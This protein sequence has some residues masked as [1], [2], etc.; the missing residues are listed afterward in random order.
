MTL[1][2]M[3]VGSIALAIHVSSV[4]GQVP[5]D[6]QADMIL[7]SA[8]KAHNDANYPFAIQ[9]Y[10][11]FL[12]KFGN[13]PQ[14]N[15]ARYQLALAYLESP[16]R[17]YDKAIEVLNPIAGNTS[18]PEHAYA[19]YYLGLSF[20]GQGLKEL[21]GMKAKPNEAVQFKQR[22]DQKFNEATQ[23]FAAATT[24][25]RAKLPKD[26]GDKLPPEFDWAA[27]ARC[28]QAEMELR[29]GKYKEAKATAEPFTKD[30]QLAK[31][32]YH[33]LGLYLHG[34]ASFQLH[35]YLVAGR[36]LTQLSPFDDPHFGL[37]ARYLLG[38]VYQ[39]T[40]QKAEAAQAFEA[41]LA[42]YE[43]QKK[44]AA[45]KLKRADLLAKDPNERMRL[46][47]IVRNP[48][49][50]HV[51]ASVF[52]SACLGYEA[53]KFG[54]ALGKFQEFAK[55]YPRSSL[56]P[57]A[58]L[59]VGF[60]QVRMKM[61]PE[62]IATLQPMLDKQPRLVDQIQFWL[63]KAQAGAAAAMTD[64]TKAAARDGGFKTAIATLRSAADK[65]NAMANSDPDAKT[66]RAEMLIELAD[67]QQ[68]AK[69]YKDAAST[70]E[71]ILNDKS[72]PGRTEELTQRLIVALHLAGEYQRSDQLANQFLKQF[73]ESALRTPV[74]FRLA[75]NAYFVALAAEKRTNLPNRQAELAKL[76]DEAAR[77]YQDVL[78]KGGEFEKINLARY[79]LAMCLF[80]KGDYDKAREILEK[81]PNA[82]RGGEL[83]YTPY[84]LA[85]CQLRQAPATVSGA[86]ETRKVLELLESAAGNLDGFISAN[87]KAAEVPDA[88]LKLG[89]CQMRQAALIA[90][91]QERAADSSSGTSDVSESPRSNSRKSLK[92]PRREWKTPSA[93]R[94][95]AIEAERL[96]NCG[97]LPRTPGRRLPWLRTRS[98]RWRHCF[99][100]RIN[101][102]RPPKRSPLPG[103][104]TSPPFRRIRIAS[105][106]CAIITGLRCKKQ[107]SSRMPARR[108]T[109]S[110][111]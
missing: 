48:P 62:A 12:Q 79:G 100:N 23:R 1:R 68:F 16:E 25:F 13:H 9:R 49:P 27:R 96:T 106:S 75:E 108:S 47:G 69:Q 18:L 56:L 102:N 35:D 107:E 95:P 37:H 101:R 38:R 6:R 81:I 92:P 64:P 3:L 26:P 78:D 19:L 80:K 33:K 5:P 77:R 98:W 76:F 2:L 42:G 73:P 109:R 17:N 32:R 65:A 30:E 88:L 59:R 14:A 85:D 84:L 82:D 4:W 83:A 40:D 10:T 111:S 60:C 71:Q 105:L 41:V 91:A 94:W 22:A 93:W 50:D 31:S 7:T 67:T 89:T 61:Y 72:L 39:V 8:R 34:F 58:Q 87:P 70:Y 44:D 46:E 86:G 45:E 54:E 51:V 36:S 97:S 74:M 55:A 43:Q 99:A 104:S 15:K 11:E 29:L 20:R 24:A 90:V 110:G 21:D 103:K 28:D 52:F 57:E 66:R 53:G 63:G